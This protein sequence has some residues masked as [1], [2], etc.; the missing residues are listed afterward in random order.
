MCLVMQIPYLG[1]WPL[2]VELY[3][4]SLNW[5]RRCASSVLFCSA[6]WLITS[7][8][9]SKLPGNCL[10][11]HRCVNTLWLKSMFTEDQ[12]CLL[13]N[14]FRVVN[15]ITWFWVNWWN[16]L[17]LWRDSVK[18]GDTCLGWKCVLGWWQDRYRS[19]VGLVKW[20]WNPHS[21]FVSCLFLPCVN[22]LQQK[23][24]LH[25]LYMIPTPRA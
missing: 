8:E 24:A 21:D 7:A 22:E 23:W 10:R 1:G 13:P 4:S 19:G 9:C 2:I 15:I 18:W 20:R 14:P 16:R 11:K 25:F 3:W 6:C 17:M 12:L 5:R